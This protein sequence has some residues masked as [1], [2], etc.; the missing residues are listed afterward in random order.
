M[1]RDQLS[2]ARQ[3]IE[4]ATETTEQ[5]DLRE[6]LQ[7]VEEDLEGLGSGEELASDGQ[8]GE[9]LDE[10]EGDLATLQEEAEGSTAKQ[11]EEARD[12]VEV[13]RQER[14]DVSDPA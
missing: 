4:Q 11:V 1:N 8:A 6:R 2:V 5:S 9:R 3:S 12:A 7:S 10:L 14:D 13:F